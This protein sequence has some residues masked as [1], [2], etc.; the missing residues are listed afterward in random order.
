MASTSIIEN[1]GI[2]I[3]YLKII[4][5]KDKKIFWIAEESDGFKWLCTSSK[6]KVKP[7]KEVRELEARFRKYIIRVSNA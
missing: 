3:E 4:R 7:L 6:R 5:I 1:K 2:I